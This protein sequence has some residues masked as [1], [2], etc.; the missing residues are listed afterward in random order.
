[1]IRVVPII[2]TE[3]T[4]RS[5]QPWAIA[6]FAIASPSAG[7]ARLVERLQIDGRVRLGSVGRRRA[8]RC[9][10]QRERR[11]ANCAKHEGHDHLLYLWRA[12]CLHPYDPLK[13][14][15]DL[16]FTAAPRRAASRSGSGC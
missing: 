8:R 5:I 6:A 9:V 14:R 10:E 13:A 1:M 12:L 4:P 3:G 2:A 15:S 11:E 16:A 7:A